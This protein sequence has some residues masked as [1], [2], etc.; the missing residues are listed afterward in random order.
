MMEINRFRFTRDWSDDVL[1]LPPILERM[2]QIKQIVEK[3]IT[4]LY[5]AIDRKYEDLSTFIRKPCNI[6][7]LVNYDGINN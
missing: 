3:T 2:H 1:L 6:P 7:V 5:Q 4:S